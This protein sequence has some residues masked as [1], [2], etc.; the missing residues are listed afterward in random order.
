MYSTI[1]FPV[2]SQQTYP[3][4]GKLQD[5][6]DKIFGQTKDLINEYKKESE[7]HC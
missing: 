6:G 3:D 5:L 4:N 7:Q 1:C 2:N